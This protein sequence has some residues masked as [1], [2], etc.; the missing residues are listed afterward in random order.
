MGYRNHYRGWYWSKWTNNGG[1]TPWVGVFEAPSGRGRPAYC[2]R[3][4][5]VTA[6]L[7]WIDRE[8]DQVDLSDQVDDPALWLHAGRLFLS[9]VPTS[10]DEVKM[11]YKDLS[12]QLHPDAGGSEEHF[13]L[14]GESR[15][16]LLEQM[17][18]IRSKK[19]R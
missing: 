1:Q 6:A 3:G 17:E 19:A 9:A 2:Y 14:L 16:F 13:K 5:D 18:S 10:E 11:A 7:K 12:K 4:V 8:V 15:S